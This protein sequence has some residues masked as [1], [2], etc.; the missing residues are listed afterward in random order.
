MGEVVGRDRWVDAKLARAVERQRR[1]IRALDVAITAAMLLA[2][3]G[4]WLLWKWA[5]G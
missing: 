1:R 5:G 4:F 3:V 2:A